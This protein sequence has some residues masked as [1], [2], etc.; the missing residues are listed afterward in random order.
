MLHLNPRL[1]QICN[2]GYIFV[3]RVIEAKVM[4]GYFIGVTKR[5]ELALTILV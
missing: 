5:Q 3:A 4:D 1:T 2:I